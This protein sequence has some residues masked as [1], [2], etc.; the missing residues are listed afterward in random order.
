MPML[1][2]VANAGLAIDNITTI[3]AT[4]TANFFMFNLHIR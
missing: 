4:H 1:P 2:L 3:I